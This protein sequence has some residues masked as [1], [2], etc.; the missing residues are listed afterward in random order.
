M[1]DVQHAFH[2]FTFGTAQ[3]DGKDFTEFKMH[4]L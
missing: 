2:Y 3:N 4:P 1:C